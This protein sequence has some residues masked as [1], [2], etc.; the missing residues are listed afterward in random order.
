M[1]CS[2]FEFII[3]E[4]FQQIWYFNLTQKRRRQM[5]EKKI[6]GTESLCDYGSHSAVHGICTPAIYWLCGWPCLVLCTDMNSPLYILAFLTIENASLTMFHFFCHCS[7]FNCN[8]TNATLFVTTFDCFSSV[9]GVKVHNL[10][11]LC[12]LLTPCPVYLWPIILWPKLPLSL[13]IP[14]CPSLH[15]LLTQET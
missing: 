10:L 15:V 6:E 11:N 8:Q 13:S 5:N 3:F 1:L 2:C 14:L 7:Y 12:T 9:S 4:M